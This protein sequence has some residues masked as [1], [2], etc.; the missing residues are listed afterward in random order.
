[1]PFC[2][3]INHKLVL[4]FFFVLNLKSYSL[5]I[6][7]LQDCIIKSILCESRG[8][9]GVLSLDSLDSFVWADLVGLSRLFEMI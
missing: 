9:F 7:Y 1:M 8:P 4:I 2:N 3:P 5:T 6:S